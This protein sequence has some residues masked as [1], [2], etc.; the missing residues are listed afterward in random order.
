MYKKI[1]LKEALLKE[2]S[3]NNAISIAIYIGNNKALFNELLKLFLHGEY[4]ITQRAAW[5]LQFCAQYHPTL[6]NACLGKLIKNLLN[7][8]LHDAVKRNT[9]RIFQD[10]YIPKKYQGLAANLCFVFLQSK[11]EPIAIKCFAMNVLANICIEQP[12]LKNELILCIEAQL[13]YA[14]AGFKSRAKKVYAL[15]NNKK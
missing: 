1:N 9:L 4:R 10:I 5:V 11:T 3:R 12:Y 15:I 13:P 14:S 2:H 6:I 7:I 8:N